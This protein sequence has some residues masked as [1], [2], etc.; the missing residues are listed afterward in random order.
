MAPPYRSLGLAA[1]PS[2][3][4]CLSPFR[5]LPHYH[6]VLFHRL[7]GDSCSACLLP[8][9]HP[10]NMPY[11]R[12]DPTPFRV[13]AGSK[14]RASPS[15]NFTI[16]H[17]LPRTIAFTAT[18]QVHQQMPGRSHPHTK[19]HWNTDQ[20]LYLPRPIAFTATQQVHQQMLAGRVL[21]HIDRI[22]RRKGDGGYLAIQIVRDYLLAIGILTYNR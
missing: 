11:I 14:P 2:L 22:R 15:S 18:Q 19:V 3:S 9:V 4:V 10:G 6:I 8:T 21:I 1:L 20:V 12:T 7:S 16:L 13:V 5:L 17:F